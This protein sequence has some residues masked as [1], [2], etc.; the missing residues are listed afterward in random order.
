MDITDASR[1]ETLARSALDMIRAARRA[2]D[3]AA[4]LCNAVPDDCAAELADAASDV[5]GTIEIVREEIAEE[6][7]RRTGMRDDGRPP[8]RAPTYASQV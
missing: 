4:R 2:L 1:A 7:A 6:I 3:E 8:S 5:L